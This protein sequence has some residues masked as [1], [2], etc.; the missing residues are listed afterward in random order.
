MVNAQTTIEASAEPPKELVVAIATALLLSDYENGG[1]YGQLRY[2]SPNPSLQ[3][4][5]KLDAR[6]VILKKKRGI[7]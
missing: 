7:L 6:K 3:A 2:T 4:R 1:P 5:W